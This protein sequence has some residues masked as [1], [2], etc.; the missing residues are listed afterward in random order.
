MNL[1][2]PMGGGGST[3]SCGINQYS[4]DGDCEKC[5]AANP[6]YTL[7]TQQCLLP[8]ARNGPPVCGFGSLFGIEY[9]DEDSPTCFDHDD[10]TKF[11]GR[12]YLPVPGFEFYKLTSTAYLPKG[13]TS[14]VT[15]DGYPGKVRGNRSRG[16][17]NFI[18]FEFK[19]PG[20]EDLR[21]ETMQLN[22][23]I[24]AGGKNICFFAEVDVCP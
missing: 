15:L 20:P 1:A 2:P 11:K 13:A 4:K 3:L 5:L 18:E 22:G 6:P 12:L 19:S 7:R 17:L 21:G 9:E 14:S 10:G 23:I 16:G 8:Y 24:V